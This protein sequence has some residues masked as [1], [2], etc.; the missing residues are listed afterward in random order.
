MDGEIFKMISDNFGIIFA[1]A[2]LL[3]MTIFAVKVAI[4]FDLNKYL[5]SRK[6][7]HLAI[8]QNLCL[9]MEPYVKGKKVGFKPF[10][11]SPS[12]TPDYYCQKCGARFLYVDEEELMKNA[13]YY[14]KNAKIYKKTLKKY[15]RHMKKAQ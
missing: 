9:H 1:C 8:A 14:T 6:K 2:M 11:F 12:G 13:L 5:E 10:L 7:K 4:T 15:N 3:I